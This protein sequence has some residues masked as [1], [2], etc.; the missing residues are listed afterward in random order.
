MKTLSL[1]LNVIRHLQKHFMWSLQ[2]SK[3]SRSA[4]NRLVSYL[5]LAIE[6]AMD[7]VKAN[8]SESYVFR[9]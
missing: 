8:G 7:T 5:I 1:A 9:V 6:V 4:P 2:L 3:V